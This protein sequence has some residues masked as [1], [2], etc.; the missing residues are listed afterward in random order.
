[1]SFLLL[2]PPQIA[3]SFWTRPFHNKSV[4]SSGLHLYHRAFAIVCLHGNVSAGM[5]GDNSGG[6]SRPGGSVDELNFENLTYPEAS[7]AEGEVLGQCY[8]FVNS[9]ATGLMF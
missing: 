7:C 6:F 3:R 8:P 4:G 5:E 9:T 2:P 1:M